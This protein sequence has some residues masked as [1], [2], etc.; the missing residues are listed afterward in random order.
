MVAENIETRCFRKNLVNFSRMGSKVVE[1][2]ETRCFRNDLVDISRRRRWL[3]KISKHGVFGKIWSIFPEW[4]ARLSRIPKQG[5]FGN[6]GCQE[7][8]NKGFSERSG[9]ERAF[10][11]DNGWTSSTLPLLRGRRAPKTDRTPLCELKRFLRYA[12]CTAHSDTATAPYS[13][14]GTRCTS[15]SEFC[16]VVLPAAWARLTPPHTAKAKSRYPLP[17]RMRCKQSTLDTCNIL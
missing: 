13:I 6:E 12:K 15:F 9:Q 8:R 7:C 16:R 1:N 2:T 5:V 11:G 3:P 14:P 17:V 10:R 4:E